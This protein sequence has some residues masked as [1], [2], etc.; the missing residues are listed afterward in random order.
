V[1]SI[2]RMAYFYCFKKRRDRILQ[3]F[4]ENLIDM[5]KQEMEF[6]QGM[7]GYL[8]WVLYNSISNER[9]VQSRPLL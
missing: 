8:K 7:A 3:R 5:L 9:M 4:V 6:L 1:P 2:D